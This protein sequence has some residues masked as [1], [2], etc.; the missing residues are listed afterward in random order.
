MYQTHAC[1]ACLRNIQK[2]K[3]KK[4]PTN[5]TSGRPVDSPSESTDDANNVSDANCR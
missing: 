2:I 3:K 1:H 4:I 5:D